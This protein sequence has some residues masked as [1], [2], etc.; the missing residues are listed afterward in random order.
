MAWAFKSLRFVLL[1][2]FCIVWGWKQSPTGADSS[3]SSSFF[4]L[5]FLLFLADLELLSLLAVYFSSNA[6]LNL[7]FSSIGTPN[8]KESDRFPVRLKCVDGLVAFCLFDCGYLGI[9]LFAECGRPLF[10]FTCFFNFSRVIIPSLLCSWFG[11]FLI[12]S[13]WVIFSFQ[14]IIRVW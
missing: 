10:L 11:W 12:I 5:C 14:Y 6:F 13:C 2:I 4:L 9:W 3:S 7:F 1:D 8:F